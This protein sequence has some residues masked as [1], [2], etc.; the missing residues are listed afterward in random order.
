MMRRLILVAALVLAIVTLLSSATRI[1][2]GERAVVRRFGRIREDK[3]GPGLHLFL[4][5]GMDRVERVKVNQVREVTVGQPLA[6][7]EEESATPPGQL[8]TGDHN[9]IDLQVKL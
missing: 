3:P 6:D 8:L 1:Q 2:P 9:L 7:S 4:P 5:F